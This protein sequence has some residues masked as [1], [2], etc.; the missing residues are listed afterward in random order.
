MAVHSTFL[1]QQGFVVL[2]GGLATELEYRG[3]SLNDPLWSAK[4]LLSAPEI[5]SEV[6][7]SYFLAGADVAI[8]S[9]YQAT[10]RGLEA[11]GLSH[12]EAEQVLRL[13]VGLAL[14]AR[15]RFWSD[16]QNRIGRIRPLIAASVGP[17]GAFLHDG[18]EYRGDYGISRDDLKTFHRGRLA[19]LA[20]SEAD[21]IACESIPSL[22]EARALT[23][24]LGESPDSQTW[25]SFI[26]KDDTYISDGTPFA[27]AVEAVS[28]SESVVAVGLNC[29]APRFVNSLLEKARRVTDKPLVAY[30][31]SGEIY[32]I[33]TCSWQAMSD[34]PGIE[35]AV[36]GWRDRG[37]CLIG[38]CCRTTPGT[39]RRIRNAL[40]SAIAGSGSK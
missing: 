7:Y 22:L 15:D 14:Q 18:S 10:F 24:L 27:D 28:Q 30:P 16:P 9:S 4:I 6:H 21:L 37:A 25:I 19:I 33:R 1:E 32:D 38:G 8:T 31:N 39:I 29:T 2:D 35:N 20:A 36:Q 11:A 23:D 3:V 26:C 17:Y 40:S 5:I 34:L 12:T 13:S